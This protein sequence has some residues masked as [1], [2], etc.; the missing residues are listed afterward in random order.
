ILRSP[1]REEF[2]DQYANSSFLFIQCVFL[3]RDPCSN[4]VDLAGLIV[5]SRSAGS[6]TNQFLLKTIDSGFDFF[7]LGFKIRLISTTLAKTTRQF[8]KPRFEVFYLLL[9]RL[10]LRA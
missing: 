10:D 4:C 5:V 3:F 2:I 8:R 1:I 7:L 6:S 9:Q